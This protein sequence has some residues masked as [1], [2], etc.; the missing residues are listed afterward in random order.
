MKLIGLTGGMGTGKSVVAEFLRQRGWEVVSSDDMGRD[1]LNT[2]DV[3][4]EITRLFGAEV[5]K[6]GIV[7]SGLISAVVFDGSDAGRGKLRE[8]NRI[9]HPR[10][11]EKQAELISN[12]IASG[13]PLLVIESAL[14]YEVGLEDGF[15]WIIVVDAPIDVCIARVMQRTGMTPEQVQARMM[16]QMPSKE[17]RVLADFVIENSGTL[18][19]LEHATDTITTIIEMLPEPQAD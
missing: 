10:V 8:L 12:R 7:D 9:I 5:V 11:L 19:D 3:R 18:D 14:I 1:V 4:K 6:N 16:E 17:K 13:S 2:I 15:D